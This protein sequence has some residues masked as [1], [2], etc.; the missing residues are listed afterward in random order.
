MFM[1]A[2][3][4]LA[5]YLFTAGALASA[6]VTIIALA[7][8]VYTALP[9]LQKEGL[10]FLFGTVWD[11]E[12]HQYGIWNFFIGTLMLTAVAIAIAFPLGIATAIYLSEFAPPW[13][14]KSLSTLI[15]LLVGIPSVV[16]GIFG[17]FVL[18]NIFKTTINPF[19]A[20]TLGFIPLFRNNNPVGMDGTGVLLASSVLALMILP[21]IVALSREA[22]RDV[23]VH[24]REG[25][26]ALGATGWETIRNIV[27]PVSLAGITTGLI[28]AVMRAMGE[29]MAV[30]MLMGG[31]SGAPTSVLDMGTTMT[32]KILNDI[33]YYVMVPEGKSALFA[34]GA[35]L[36]VMEICFVVGMRFVSRHIRKRYEGIR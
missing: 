15:E 6:A 8:I 24:I 2:K 9:A 25:S 13:L 28:L 7:F 35:V 30:V 36:F 33:G 19:V 12:T 27:I 32:S 16:F 11:Y 26:V 14:D 18:R 3:P 10:N 31:A 23:P 21:T 22:M 20:N 29:T 17:F 5:R 1:N 34:I 4:D